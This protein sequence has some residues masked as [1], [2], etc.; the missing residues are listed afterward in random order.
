MPAY[1]CF[2]VTMWLP[3]EHRAKIVDA[4]APM[5]DANASDSSAPS[6]SATARSNERTVGLAYRL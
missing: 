4:S 2:W 5:P 3:L 6:S 1:S